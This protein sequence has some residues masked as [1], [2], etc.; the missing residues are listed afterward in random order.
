M[1][2]QWRASDSKSGVHYFDENNVGT[3]VRRLSELI[4]RYRRTGDIVIMSLHWGGNWG[5]DPEE[6]HQEFARALID[7]AQVRQGL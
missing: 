1:P 3:E 7:N 4:K 6:Y 5:F 2:T